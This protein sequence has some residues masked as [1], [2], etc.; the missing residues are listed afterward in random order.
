MRL[1]A[2]MAGLQAGLPQ[3]ASDSGD[4]SQVAPTLEPAGRD[5]LARMLRYDPRR[6]ITAKD[7]TQHP[8]FA[9]I[10]HLEAQHGGQPDGF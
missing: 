1:P 8:Y 4:C 9:D 3:A 2:L 7:A 10:H 6:R 5:L